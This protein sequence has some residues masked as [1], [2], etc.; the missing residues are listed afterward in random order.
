MRN[1][2]NRVTYA[3]YR[4]FS[5]RVKQSFNI[6]I[7]ICFVINSFIVYINLILDDLNIFL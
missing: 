3:I 7:C 1:I 2:I 6:K 5:K 4:L